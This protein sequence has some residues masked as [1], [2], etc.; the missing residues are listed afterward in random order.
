LF[1]ALVEEDISTVA[2]RYV[3]HS[4]NGGG[5]GL[6][7]LVTV[8]VT[9]RDFEAPEAEW[10]ALGVEILSTATALARERAFIDATAEVELF[11]GSLKANAKL[12]G[13]FLFAHA[14]YGT[15][16][17][18]KGFKE[19]VAEMRKDAHEYAMAVRAAIPEIV[20]HKQPVAPHDVQKGRIVVT[21][22]EVSELIDR[23]E[24]LKAK[25]GSM[26]GKEMD[27]ELE[28][29]G[30]LFRSLRRKL[31]A[32]DA[33][34]VEQYLTDGGLPTPHRRPQ[35]P[36]PRQGKEITRPD[37][38]EELRRQVEEAVHNT[39]PARSALAPGP[40]AGSPRPRRRM[41]FGRAPVRASTGQPKLL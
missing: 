14:A 29:V 1:G 2:V 38:F 9:I 39:G 15:I 30:R 17:D 6:S 34:M 13:A 7:T 5:I 21:A 31:D 10:R 27:A 11:D 16:A 22:D 23:L 18:Y 41:F 32:N 20:S 28:K 40:R 25:S 37:S 3:Y 19:S 35:A 26:S 4:Q 8:R 12:V 24:K 36:T 33:K